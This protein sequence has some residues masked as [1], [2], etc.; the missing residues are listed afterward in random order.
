M[1]RKIEHQRMGKSELGWLESWFHFSFAEYYNPQNMN[2]GKLRVVNDDQ[3]TPGTGF[4]MHPHNDMEIVT[5]VISGQLTHG[6]SMNNQR[7]LSRGQVQYMSAGTGVVHSE[8]NQGDELLRLLQ[9]WIYPD[10]KGY[11]PA[12]GDFRFPWEDRVDRWLPIVSNSEG[13]A[14]IRI[15]QDMNLYV[16]EL[17][18]QQTLSFSC[19]PGRQLYLIQIE[20]ESVV[21]GTGLEQRDTMELQDED[22]LVSAVTSSHLMLF[23]MKA[24]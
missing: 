5:Y 6:D 19:A 2:Y 1:I 14:P 3:I 8:H 12:Y 11:P 7:T 16:T 15:H 17:S 9:I 4:D 18:A 10:R 13:E 20:G 24:E 21:N 23:E 22:L